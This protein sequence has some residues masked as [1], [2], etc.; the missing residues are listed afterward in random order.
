M[1]KSPEKLLTGMLLPQDRAR[2][3]RYSFERQLDEKKRENEE[4]K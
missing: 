4:N 2:L 1:I 3:I